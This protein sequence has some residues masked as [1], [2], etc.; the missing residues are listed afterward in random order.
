ML[1]FRF[2]EREQKMLLTLKTLSQGVAAKTGL[3]LLMILR[4]PLDFKL[5][6]ALLMIINFEI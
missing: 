4:F 3:K 2:T 6:H 5:H 1:N